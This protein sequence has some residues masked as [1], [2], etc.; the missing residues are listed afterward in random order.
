MSAPE[1]V[2]RRSELQD[3]C[4]DKPILV[5]GTG[6]MGTLVA[7]ATARSG[8]PVQA[9]DVIDGAALAARNRALAWS[10]SGEKALVEENFEVL[11]SLEE[12]SENVQLAFENVYEDLEIKTDLLSTLGALLP[13][14]VYMGSNTSSL[15][16]SPLAQASGRPDRF[17]NLNFTDPR[18]SKLV[19]LMGCPQTADQTLDF[20]RAWAKQIGMVPVTAAR[21]QMGYCFN[22]LWRVVK[23]EVL[24]QIG[25][26]Y[27]TPE[28]I[29]RAW[30]L[31]FGTEY[32]PCGLMDSINLATVLRV[33]QQY[34]L[35]SGDESDRPP[36][37]LEDMVADGKRGVSS[38]AG[39]YNYPDPVYR[40]K[41]WLTRS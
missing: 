27:A 4:P 32:G 24:R 7:W 33:E 30:M 6:T 5:V 20:A 16:C 10:S 23:K 21:E 13:A 2:E 34:F 22:R 11:S 1:T 31:S 36:R 35:E 37:F 41:D 19:E 26:E 39:F 25:E 9:F 14:N 40:Q 28:D 3:F 18:A 29:D 38:G 12:A 8:T 15:T 17:F